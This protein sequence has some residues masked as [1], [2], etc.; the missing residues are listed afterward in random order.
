M[1]E[2]RIEIPKIQRDYAQGRRDKD[3][4]K[5]VL[6]TFKKLYKDNLIYQGNRIINWC[7][8]HQTSL[9]DLEV[10]HQEVEGK[11]YYIK[12]PFNNGKNYIVI[13]TTRP[14]TMLADTGVAVNPRDKRY[15]HLIG[16]EFDVEWIEGK[17]KA[18]VISDECIDMTLGTGAM[19][20]TPAHSLVDFELAEKHNLDIQQI[21][22]FDGNI[23]KDVSSEFGGMS[24]LDARE[25]I[26]EKL[27]KKG[28]LVE[29]DD[30]Y[31]NKKGLDRGDA[32]F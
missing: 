26:V 28:L 17:I 15:K 30:K 9:S 18:K 19:T 31:I 16:K 20:I 2:Y 3:I 32:R 29:I 21:I 13:A 11:L 27:D 10:T 23:L 22:D 6:D 4:V 12:Y 24:I 25:K 8:Y 14:E 1:S 5:I 7:P